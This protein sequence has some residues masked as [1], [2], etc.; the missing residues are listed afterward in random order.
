M[1]DV[2]TLAEA[3]AY[4][5][6]LKA[7][8]KTLVVTNGCF[9]ILHRGHASYLAEAK[10]LGDAL[11][12]LV[13]SDASVRALKGPARPVNAENDRAFLLTQLKA[14]DKAVI[15]DGARCDR[16]LAALAPDVYTKAGDYTLD[17]LDASERAALEKHHVKIVFMPF[18]DGFSTTKVIEKMQR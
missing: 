7:D 4:R 1:S 10:K 17:K 3:V 9:D 15:F 2:L 13:N 18:V 12:V 14:V 16:E 6:Q 11:L 8:D 5:A